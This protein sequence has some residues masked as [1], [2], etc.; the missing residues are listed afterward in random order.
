MVVGEVKVSFSTSKPELVGNNNFTL[1]LRG[2]IE[3]CDPV[4]LLVGYCRSV[5]VLILLELEFIL[6]F[7]L[8][9]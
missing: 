7:Y 1:R 8:E 6:L 4:S 9:I 2:A 3:I 5:F